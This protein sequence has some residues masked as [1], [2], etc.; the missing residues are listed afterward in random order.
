MVLISGNDKLKSLVAFH[1]NM[2]GPN[3]LSPFGK[4]QEQILL[5]TLGSRSARLSKFQNVS[6]SLKWWFSLLQSKY[7]LINNSI[8]HNSNKNTNFGTN[9]PSFIAWDFIRFA[10][11]C[12]LSFQKQKSIIRFWCENVLVLIHNSIRGHQILRWFLEPNLIN[13]NRVWSTFWNDKGKCT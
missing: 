8:S 1:G 13:C 5:W 12:F 4:W 2:E 10:A 11:K 9:S 6:T 3:S 7:L